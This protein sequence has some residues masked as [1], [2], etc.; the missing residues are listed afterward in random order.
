MEGLC[1]KLLYLALLQLPLIHVHDW[2][3][4]TIVEALS[5]ELRLV[6]KGGLVRNDGSL[7]VL[8]LLLRGS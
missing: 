1:N 2:A 4:I 6:F 3:S 5:S 8:L 7:K